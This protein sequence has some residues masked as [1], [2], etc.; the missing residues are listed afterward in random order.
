M[1]YTRCYNI[2]G[3]KNTFLYSIRYTVIPKELTRNRNCIINRKAWFAASE[4]K[5]THRSR[6]LIIR[7]NQFY[8]VCAGRKRRAQQKIY[9]FQ[10]VF[11]A[12]IEEHPCIANPA[13]AFA[14][15]C[16]PDI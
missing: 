2:Y 1:I 8:S 3:K 4:S 15:H 5:P 11:A 12:V 13:R 10:S 14:V 7:H 6:F 9:L 16:T